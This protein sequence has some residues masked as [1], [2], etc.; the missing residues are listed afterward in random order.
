MDLGEYNRFLAAACDVVG[1]MTGDG[2]ELVDAGAEGIKLD[3]ESRF[4][5]CVSSPGRLDAVD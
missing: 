2:V 1:A 5:L 3:D 4:M